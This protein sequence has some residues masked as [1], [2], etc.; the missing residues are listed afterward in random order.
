[1]TM[2]T[3]LQ[4]ALTASAQATLGLFYDFETSGLPDWSQ[5]SESPQQPHVVQVGAQLVNLDTRVVVQSLDVIVRPEGWTIPDEVAQVHGITTEMAMDLGV[6]EGTALEMLLELWKPTAPRLRIGHNESFDAR[7]MRID[8]FR[9]FDQQLADLWKAG[10]A[11]CTQ[12]LSSPIL[13]LPPTAKMI[14]AR[15]N[16][17]KSP[18]LRE[19]YEFF[20][21]RPLSGAHNAM[22]DVDACK[23]VYFAI[24]DRELGVAA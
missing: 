21:G 24:K 22:V 5:P 3:P 9:F 18:N 6:P 12:T 8:M 19:A 17:R 2:S 20:T 13:N 14:A 11:H 23:T 4:A 7:I 1:M 16:H 15:R 10:E